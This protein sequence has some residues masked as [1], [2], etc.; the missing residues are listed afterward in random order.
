M[1]RWRVKFLAYGLIMRRLRLKDEVEPF[2]IV[3]N[4]LGPS[5]RFNAYAFRLH[6]SG[7]TR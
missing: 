5:I 7:T 6:I 2:L 4:L 3:S 1:L